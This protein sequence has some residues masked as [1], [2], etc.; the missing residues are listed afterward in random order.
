MSV[1]KGFKKQFENLGIFIM[2]KCEGFKLDSAYVTKKDI[3]VY[4][5]SDIVVY[6]IKD[7]IDRI[8]IMSR[9]GNRLYSVIFKND[10]HI[11]Q[12][13][14]CKELDSQ[15]LELLESIAVD[16]LE[17]ISLEY[18]QAEFLNRFFKR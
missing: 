1:T 6:A 7:Q 17:R 11:K 2:D 18:D 5:Y 12:G 16:R 14:K 3:V 9:K 8:D 4:K 15:V 10:F 13:G